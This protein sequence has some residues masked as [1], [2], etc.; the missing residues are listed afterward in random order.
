[1]INL[2]EIKTGT[3]LMVKKDILTK[4]ITSGQRAIIT[5]VDRKL[6]V[7]KA[8]IQ[9]LNADPKKE[10]KVVR[11]DEDSVNKY[12]EEVVKV[13]KVENNENIRINPEDIKHLH[14]VDLRLIRNIYTNGKI[15]VVILDGGHK[16]IAKCNTEYDEYDRD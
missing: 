13:K 11:Y 10:S 12:F 2:Q 1:M 4:G 8:T 15:T 5:R 9:V 3:E 16:G 14:G 7:P 6:E